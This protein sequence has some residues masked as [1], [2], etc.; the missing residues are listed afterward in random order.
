M[1]DIVAPAV[2]LIACL[3]W[4]VIERRKKKGKP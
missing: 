2:L 1:G 4:E 3:I